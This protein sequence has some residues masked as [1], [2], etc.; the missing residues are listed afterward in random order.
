MF[1]LIFACSQCVTNHFHVETRHQM[2]ALLFRPPYFVLLGRAQIHVW[3]PNTKPYK[4]LFDILAN[5]SSVENHTDLRLGQVKFIYP[6]SN[7]SQI[8]GFRSSV[9]LILVFDDVTV[10]TTN[11]HK[12]LFLFCLTRMS[13]STQTGHT[14]LLW[15]GSAQ[16]I[17]G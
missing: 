2:F 11:I 5:N 6:Y 17:L 14:H 9:V 16:V 8:L 13:R 4:F 1:R 10:K 3:H 15:A 7:T 12:K